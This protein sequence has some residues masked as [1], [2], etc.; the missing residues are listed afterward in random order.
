MHG[1]TRWI[2]SALAAWVGIV[3]RA[4]RTTVVLVVMLGAGGTYYAAGNLGI[5]TDTADMIAAS[6]PWRRDFIDYRE[7]FPARD[8]NLVVV[9]E[10]GTSARAERYAERIAARLREAPEHYRSVFLAGSGEFF[11]RNGLLYLGVGELEGLSERLV[12]AQPLLGLL[13]RDFNGARVIDVVERTVTEDAAPAAELAPLYEELELTLERAAS[14]DDVMP[15]RWHR[16][17][18]TRALDDTRRLIVVQPVLD[19]SRV[20][21]AGAAIERLRAL[22][23]AELAGGDDVRVGLTGT[24]AMEHEEMVSVSRGAGVAAAAA[25]AM[26][27]VVLYWALR[28]LRLLAVSLVTLVV[29]LGC[30]AAFAALAVGQLNLLSVAFA[31][32]YVGLGVDFILHINLRF[33][34]LLAEGVQ[35]AA[36]IVET[37]RGVGTSLVICAVTTAAGF[38]SFIPTPFDGVSELGLISGTGMFISLAVSVTLLPALLAL[39]SARGF[40]GAREGR[41]AARPWAP[42]SRHPKIVAFAC[43]LLALATFASLPRARFDSNPVNLRDPSSESVTVLRELAADS[44]APLLNLV[45]IADD[46]ATAAAWADALER[47]PE[48]R[49]VDT[50]DELVPDDQPAKLAVLDDLALV[51][52]PGFAELE[53]VPEQPDALEAALVSLERTLRGLAA[54]T[55]AERRLTQAV[56]RLDAA[57]GALP[58]GAASARLTALGR[59]LTERLP[60]EL[61]RLETALGAEA[62]GRAALPD[63]LAERWV[64]GAGRE[65][66]EIVPAENVD[67]GAAAARFVEAVRDVVASATGM[68]VVHQ[69]ASATVVRSFRLALTYAFVMV[70][71]ILLVLLRRPSDI[72]LVIVPIVFAA[73]ATAGLTVWI[74]MPFNFANIIALPLL[75]GVGVDNGIHMV[76]RMR[77]E[78]PRDGDLLATSTARAV[79]ASGLTTIASFGNLAW[80]A[81]LG[82]ASMGQLLTLGMAVTLLAT[83]VLL[84]ALLALKAPR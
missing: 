77:T 1:A 7:T 31:V 54:P 82:M 9:V 35:R 36:A 6:L 73:G 8:R 58:A 19:F 63:A 28:S 34:E 3:L 2:G 14:G 30:T 74:D 48:V 62:F 26:V 72:V 44:E 4:A 84:P 38:Y 43:V 49:E 18:G 75:V 24:V 76:H 40:R 37:I 71:V 59:A 83:L 60:A 13:A 29:G 61:E 50:L 12:A 79:L 11:E 39:T 81:H 23:D 55:A 16:L 5:N 67:D 25:L 70:V 68:P 22:V 10:A 65:L 64:S 56:A 53:P 32:L 42:L 27:A 57:L 52:G 33:K 80:S 21:P 45:A 20:Q 46:P 51:L 41:P 66:I 47:L 15:L 78:P 17:V 69:E